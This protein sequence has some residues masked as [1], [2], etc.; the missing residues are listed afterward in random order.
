MPQSAKTGYAAQTGGDFAA[1][2]RM[3]G[4]DLVY[5]VAV[6]IAARRLSHVVYRVDRYDDI[7]VSTA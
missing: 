4:D 2:E 1:M 5:V 3:F 6:F 7:G